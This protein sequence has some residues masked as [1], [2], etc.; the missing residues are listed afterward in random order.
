[1]SL[2]AWL[3]PQIVKPKTKPQQEAI[4]TEDF[5]SNPKCKKKIPVNQMKYTLRVK[6]EEKVFCADC[7]RAKLNPLRAPEDR[8]K[9]CPA[10]TS[11]CA[12]KKC[13]PEISVDCEDKNDPKTCC[14]CTTDFEDEG[15]E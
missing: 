4:I 1:M 8:G 2:D 3:G 14:G 12:C 10:D 6:G 5:C 7:A 11:G 9:Y 13:D 15:G